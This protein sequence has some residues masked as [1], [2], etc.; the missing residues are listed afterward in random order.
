LYETFTLLT[1]SENKLD[2]AVSAMQKL[3]FMYLLLAFVHV[4]MHVVHFMH[5]YYGITN[6]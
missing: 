1:V 4:C 6:Y 3:Q 5:E 2:M